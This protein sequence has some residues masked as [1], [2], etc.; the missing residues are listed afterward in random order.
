MPSHSFL[1]K[2]SAPG[3]IILLG[4]HAVVYG[5]PAIAVPVWE[6]T[7]EAAIAQNERGCG[8]TIIAHDFER[9]IQLSNA[10][11]DEP[12]ALAARKT[13]ALVGL[14]AEPDWTIGLRST[15]P[16]ASGLGSGAAVSAAIIRAICH[17]LNV[18]IDDATI[19]QLIYEC[20]TLHHGTPSGIDNTV[21]AHGMPVWFIK[22]EPPVPF[23]QDKPFKIV[24]GDSGIMAPTKESVGDVRL[25]W[26]H[27]PEKY[28]RLFDAI[29][30]LVKEGRECIASGD[31]KL[32]GEIFDRNHTLLQ[33]LSVSHPLLDVMVQAA[34]DAGAFGAKLSGGGRGGNMIALVRNEE[35]CAVKNTLMRTGANRVLVTTI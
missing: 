25:G 31:L 11:E 5:R 3:K 34:R 1:S 26:L 6:V 32:L 21:I 22:G 29:E 30:H 33:Q 35:A 24:I 7:A 28:E 19:S 18:N 9:E 14:T 15:I 23:K 17:Q 2:S 10:P 13:F 16:I 4:E 27:E 8:C 20:E 12:L